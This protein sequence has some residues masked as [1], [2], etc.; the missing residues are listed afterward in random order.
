MNG[1]TTKH[2]FHVKVNN[3]GEFI[4]NLISIIILIFISSV[5]YPRAGPSLQIQAP[6]LKFCPKAGLS[7]QNQEPRLSFTRDE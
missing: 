2:A 6:S 5:F 7:L 1:K 3:A 4:M